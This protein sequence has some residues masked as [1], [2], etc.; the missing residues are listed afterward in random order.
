MPMRSLTTARA[1]CEPFHPGLLD[2]LERLPLPDR[3]A[4]GSPVVEIYRKHGGP[5]LLVP[6]EYGGHA[7]TPLVATRVQRGLASVSPSLGVATVMHHFT[8]AML[9]RLAETATR[10]TDAQLKVLSSVARDN[11]LLASGW[12]E[13]RTEQNILTPAVVADRTS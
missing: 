3:E 7:V 2:E 6:A 13:G 5:G 1:A 11:L 10:L 9:F 4:A 12:A 8:V